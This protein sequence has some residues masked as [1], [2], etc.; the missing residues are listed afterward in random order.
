MFTARSD[1]GYCGCARNNTEQEECNTHLVGNAMNPAIRSTR[2]KGKAQLLKLPEILGL[3]DVRDPEAT[4][5]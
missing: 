3:H 2:T 4:E 1:R 5:E